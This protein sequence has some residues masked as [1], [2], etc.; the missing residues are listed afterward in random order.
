MATLLV[1]AERGEELFA[2][3]PELTPL[4]IAIVL[5]CVHQNRYHDSEF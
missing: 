4:I 3:N 1:E 2:E 5:I